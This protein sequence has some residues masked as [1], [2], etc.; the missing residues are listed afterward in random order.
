[1]GFLDWLRKGPVIDSR[2]G[3]LDFIETRAAFLIQKNIYDYARAR[4]GPYFKVIVKEEEF[5]QSVERSRWTSY[6][7]ALSAIAEMIYGSLY[8]AAPVRPALVEGISRATLDVFDRFPVPEVLGEAAW[9]QAR[10]NLKHRITQ[11]GLH[12]PKLVKDI[13]LPSARAIYD[14]LPIHEELRKS[15]FEM[16]QNQLRINLVTMYDEFEQ[17]ADKNAML[18]AIGFHV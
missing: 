1:M 9:A 2:E 11:V 6:P 3:L 16:I 4:S 5:R 17:R 18:T 12:P 13:F 14:A 10:E 15:D 7:L 8:H